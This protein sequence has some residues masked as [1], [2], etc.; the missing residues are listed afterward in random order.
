MDNS[1][2]TA[3]EGNHADDFSDRDSTRLQKSDKS[4]VSSRT[5]KS[6]SSSSASEDEPPSKRRRRNRSHETLR[7]IDQRFEVLSHQLVSHINNMFC[8]NY[9]VM[10]PNSGSPVVPA[11]GP[12]KPIDDPFLRPSVDLND[13]SELNVSIKEP[14]IP[15]ANPDRV[16]RLT[17]MQRFDSVDWNSVR[18]TEVQKKY[19]AFPAF[20]ELKV[21]EELRH[22]EDP[23]APLRWYQMERSF[24]ALSNAFL[25][26][27][28]FVNV[29]L[30]NLID[31]SAKP[32]AQLTSS[33]IY[34]KLKELFGSDSN[35][36]SIS[37]DILQMICGKRAE[38][39][40]LRRKELL[41]S[42]KGKYFR[43][44]I[45]KIPP[46][47]EYMFSPQSL[48]AYIQKI[49]GIDKLEKDSAPGTKFAG[50][51]KSPVR[52]KSPVASTSREKP[53]R[54]QQNK[55][56]QGK[57]KKKNFDDRR[58]RGGRRDESNKGRRK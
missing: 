37:H 6:S 11:S 21:N 23:F 47:S 31:W 22:L 16:A 57:N 9:A 58:K 36:K 42:L 13:I 55:R 56:K 14:S 29:A 28:E 32:D 12:I 50:R 25:A 15:K 24:A 54:S 7:D 39:L 49:G 38:V 2:I 19:A 5:S 30:R 34:D 40:E 53:F 10:Q 18:Y 3:S 46:S 43:E 1:E 33:T 35:Y 51:S 20:T 27:N 48:S 52:P 8:A 41:K 17:S 26:Q 44:D 45:G 4:H